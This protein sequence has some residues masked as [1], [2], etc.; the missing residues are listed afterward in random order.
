MRILIENGCYDLRNMGDVAMLQVAVQRL[1]ALWPNAHIDVITNKPKLLA[2]YCPAVYAVPAN[3]RRIWFRNRILSGGILKA[4][5]RKVAGRL[6]QVWPAVRDRQPAV[7]KAIL[8]WN[9]KFRGVDT[10]ITDLDIFWEAFLGADIVVV[11][12]AGFITDAFE[13]DA[14]M[15]LSLLEAA[16]R[17]GKITAM[18]SQG[19]GPIQNFQLMEMAKKV[20]KEVDIIAIR[21]KRS[22]RPLL[23]SWGIERSRIIVTGDD[24]IEPAYNLRT[25]KSGSGIGINLRVAEYSGLQ[26]IH[27]EMVRVVLEETEN[28]FKRP[29]ISLPILLGDEMESDIKTI[30]R[31]LA[32]FIYCSIN[33]E[34]IDSPSDV[35]KRTARCGVVITGSY[36]PAV[37]AL[38]QGTPVVAIAGSDYYRDKFFGLAEQFEEGCTVVSLNDKSPMRKLAKA[39]DNAWQTK[40]ELRTI[41]LESAQHQ[42]EVGIDAYNRV[43]QMVESSRPQPV[44]AANVCT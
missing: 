11:S 16:V 23:H 25:V 35:M 24:A 8:K 17:N 44:L 22:S 18:F 40:E 1:S 15:V 13:R 28:K 33:E 30:K 21:E 38:S 27:P 43:Y 36:H 10:D 31:I 12:G 32:G 6:S 5:P 29:L 26:W 19:I 3:G 20:L 7:A 14:R 34:T 42:I 2:K 39:I 41:L 9:A 37:F 4:I